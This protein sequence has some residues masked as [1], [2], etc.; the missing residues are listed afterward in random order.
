MVWADV[1][2]CSGVSGWMFVGR[3][4]GHIRT[5]RIR[6]VLAALLTALTLF[7]GGATLTAC[8][9]AG[10]NQD[11][12]TNDDSNKTGGNDQEELDQDNGGNDQGDVNN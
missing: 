6:R 10:Q 7:G 12:G 4:S 11:D 3:P 8:Q 1:V 5:M 2:T 9:A